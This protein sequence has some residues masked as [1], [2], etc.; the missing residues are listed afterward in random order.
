MIGKSYK[1]HDI[2][3]DKICLIFGIQIKYYLLITISTIIH[4]FYKIEIELI[5]NF[6]LLLYFIHLIN[7]IKIQIKI[8]YINF[9]DT[10][11]LDFCDQNW[12]SNYINKIQRLGF[13]QNLI[14]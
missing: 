5:N 1:S 3:K 11:W 8:W 9:F 13:F 10:H 12:I 7:D 2:F 4:N 6:E 14:F